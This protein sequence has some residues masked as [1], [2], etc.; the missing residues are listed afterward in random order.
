MV[1]DPVLMLL[2]D[3]QKLKRTEDNVSSLLLSHVICGI[4]KVIK[5]KEDL[6]VKS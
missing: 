1:S 4:C 3:E 6:K 5:G 2:T